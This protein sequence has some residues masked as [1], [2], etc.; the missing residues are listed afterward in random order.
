[1]E[2]LD[3]GIVLGLGQVRESDLWVRLLTPHHG[4]VLVFAFGGSRSKKRFCGCLGILNELR[5]RV[6]TSRNGRFL[7]LQ[8]ALLLNGPIR[9]RTD[10]NR[11]GAFINCIKFLEVI[12]VTVDTAS[13]TYM[14][15]KDLLCHFEE[16]TII[17]DMI[18]ILFRLR[19]VSDQGYAPTFSNCAKCSSIIVDKGFF[20]VSD[21]LIVCPACMDY[22]KKPLSIGSKS[23][24]L[25]KHVQEVS[26]SDWKLSA[27]TKS[28]VIQR[29]ECTKIINAFVQYHLG[30]SWDKGRFCRV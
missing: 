7:N 3:S 2:W 6:Q 28:A 27:N 5:V 4:I 18:P 13:A 21:G 24:E 10:R 12:G 29:N 9:L 8:E 11:L 17:Y 22:I 23:L 1:M 25:L 15:L 16:S 20:G 26:P 30:I 14:L 19:L